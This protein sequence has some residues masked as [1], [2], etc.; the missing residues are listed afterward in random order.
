MATA[1]ATSRRLTCITLVFRIA[2]G[3]GHVR[4]AD[5]AHL[6]ARLVPVICHEIGWPWIRAAARNATSSHACSN[7]RSVHDRSAESLSPGSRMGRRET[8][9]P[10]RRET[11]GE[12]ALPANGAEFGRQLVRVELRL[13]FAL[14]SAACKLRERRLRQTIPCP[15]L[16]RPSRTLRAAMRC[17][18]GHP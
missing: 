14:I 17:P 16:T 13:E 2:H 10:R 8:T 1:S 12:F 11:P 9:T 4:S 15:P 18:G 7:L 3:Y 5:P 6:R